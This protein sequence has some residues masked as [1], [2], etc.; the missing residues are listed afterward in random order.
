M[1]FL[2]LKYINIFTVKYSNTKYTEQ[3]ES[4]CPLMST[5]IFLFMPN[6]F[7]GGN[8]ISKFVGHLF[9]PFYI[10][11]YVF[12]FYFTL[13]YIMYRL[14]YMYQDLILDASIKNK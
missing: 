14:N 2:V 11:I 8:Y 1:L 9:S 12:L 4:I 3:N 7:P 5:F 13:M 6:S 10:D